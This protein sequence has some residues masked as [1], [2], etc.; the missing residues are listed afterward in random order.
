MRTPIFPLKD[1][2]AVAMKRYSYLNAYWD[3]AGGSRD[4]HRVVRTILDSEPDAELVRG[5]NG[6]TDSGAEEVGTDVTV[7]SE[8]LGLQVTRARMAAAQEGHTALGGRFI[9]CI[10]HALPFEIND[11]A[12]E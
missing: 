4:G 3:K 7:E 2:A 9:G 5:A 1:T 12:V 10:I 11:L 6:T 8:L